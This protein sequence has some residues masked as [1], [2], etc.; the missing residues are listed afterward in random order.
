MMRE[1]VS[2]YECSPITPEFHGHPV[3]HPRPAR[4]RTLRAREACSEALS[5]L[6]SIQED[7][8]VVPGTKPERRPEWWLGHLQFLMG[9]L[10]LTLEEEDASRCR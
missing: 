2:Q 9:N 8:S 5:V 7:L 6:A 1:T 4:C 3:P 10:L